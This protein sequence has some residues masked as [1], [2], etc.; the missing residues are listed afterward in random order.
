M[1]DVSPAAQQQT[2]GHLQ[3]DLAKLG[4]IIFTLAIPHLKSV[5]THRF[6]DVIDDIAMDRGQRVLQISQAR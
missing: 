3:H 6:V 4:A 2:G 1:I 5:G